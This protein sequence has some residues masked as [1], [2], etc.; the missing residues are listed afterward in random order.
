MNSKSELK[1]FE[2]GI[3]GIP[4]VAAATQTF[5]EAIDDGVDGF[6]ASSAEE[7]VGKIR[8]INIE[9]GIYVSQW[10]KGRTKKCSGKIYQQKQC[11]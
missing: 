3:L 4:T 8:K 10:G 5:R 11:Q 7:W 2:A 9:T 1:F 6:V